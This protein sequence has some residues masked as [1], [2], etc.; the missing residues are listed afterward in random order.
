MFSATL[1]RTTSQVHRVRWRISVMFPFPISDPRDQRTR[2]DSACAEKEGRTSGGRIQDVDDGRQKWSISPKQNTLAKR[3]GSPYSSPQH[4]RKSKWP[5]LLEFVYI[6]CR[7]CVR[8]S[9]YRPN[10][11]FGRATSADV[12]FFRSH[13]RFMNKKRTFVHEYLW[14]SCWNIFQSRVQFYA[15]PSDAVYINSSLIGLLS[16]IE[17]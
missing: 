3:I 1:L 8:A 13:R 9:V 4:W 6:L 17:N 5:P 15:F 11:F 14:I 10:F 7:A 2:F 16:R 12:L